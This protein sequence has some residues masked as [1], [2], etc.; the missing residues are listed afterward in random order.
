MAL[1]EETRYLNGE[2]DS[3]EEHSW[4]HLEIPVDT[5]PDIRRIKLHQN[6]EIACDVRYSYDIGRWKYEVDSLLLFYDPKHGGLLEFVHYDEGNLSVVVVH[7]YQP[8]ERMKTVTSLNQGGLGSSM[9]VYYDKEGRAMRTTWDGD[10]VESNLQEYDA[11]NNVI[12][13]YATDSTGHA[14]DSTTYTYD[15]NNRVIERIEHMWAGELSVPPDRT[16]FER[17]IYG[18]ITKSTEPIYLD[19]KFIGDQIYTY[20][21]AY[22]PQGNWTSKVQWQNGLKIRSWKRQ[23]WY[24]K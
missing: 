22:D 23:Y 20:E 15:E 11:N 5:L 1:D 13:E 18:N 4:T 8:K 6:G 14:I 10:Y 3:L 21:Y 7:S 17:D 9:Y 16:I 24:R 12:C 19:E 2:V